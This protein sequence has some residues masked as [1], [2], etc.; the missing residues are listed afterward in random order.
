MNLGTGHENTMEINAMAGEAGLKRVSWPNSDDI[1]QLKGEAKQRLID[2][3]YPVFTSLNHYRLQKMKEELIKQCE[4]EQKIMNT[5]VP[6]TIMEDLDDDEEPDYANYIVCFRPLDKDADKKN[7]TGRLNDRGSVKTSFTIVG[8]VLA[9]EP[10][11]V[12]IY[13]PEDDPDEDD[14]VFSK[15]FI[16]DPDGVTIY[17]ESTE[18]TDGPWEVLYLEGKPIYNTFSSEAFK[19]S[20]QT[21]AVKALVKSGVSEWNEGASEELANE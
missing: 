4:A 12:E 11:R 7:W 13:D 18:L 3:L 19:H 16:V 1:L 20:L 21:A 9:G 2:W 15:K 10:N 8:F 6:V 14:P 17:L 5:V